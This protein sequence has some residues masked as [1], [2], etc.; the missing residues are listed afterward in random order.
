MIAVDGL[1]VSY[2]DT[3]ALDGISLSIE[4]GSFVVLVGRNGSGKTTLL[5]QLSGLSE[6]DSGAVIIDGRNVHDD[7]RARALVGRVFEDPV[8]QI[9][10]ATVRG[11]VAFGPENLGLSPEMIDE[12]VSAALATVE[13]EGKGDDSV[14]S[15]SG[16][17]RARLAIAGALAIQPR[18]L[19][20]DEPTAGLDHPGRQAVLQRLRSAN[21]DGTGVILATHDLRELGS[22][23]DRVIG[24]DRG[25][26]SLDAEPV[27]AGDALPDLGVRV[28]A[29][30]MGP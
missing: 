28:P 6:P 20:L 26:V 21:A 10:G 5:D 1:T 4:S 3:P 27:D 12:R 23:T 8:D 15:L 11:D 14:E 25:A 29:D 30:W 18:Y 7:R 16:G 2:D 19:V 22:V 17:E 9:L 13:L 24:L